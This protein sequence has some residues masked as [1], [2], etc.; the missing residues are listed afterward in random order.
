MI[1]SIC[2]SAALFFVFTPESLS[3]PSKHK[4]L[5]SALHA[6]VLLQQCC[7][8]QQVCSVWDSPKRRGYG[9]KKGMMVRLFYELFTGRSNRIVV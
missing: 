4:A 8:I 9:G 6:T 1:K 5:Q 7:S 3:E 2:L